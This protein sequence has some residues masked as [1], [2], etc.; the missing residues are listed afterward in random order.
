VSLPRSKTADVLRAL[1]IENDT[2]TSLAGS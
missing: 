1:G 2:A